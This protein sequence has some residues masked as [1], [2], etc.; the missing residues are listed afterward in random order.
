MEKKTTTNTT[1]TCTF[2]ANLITIL[3]SYL[4]FQSAF[5]CLSKL[6]KQ[7][8]SY[9]QDDGV[10]YLWKLLFTTE[11]SCFEYPDHKKEPNETYF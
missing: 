3:V 5:S 10:D 8:N 9:F 11:F 2:D 7:M 4:D 1:L 6:N